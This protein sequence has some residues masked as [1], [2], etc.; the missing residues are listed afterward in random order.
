MVN[1]CSAPHIDVRRV[2]IGY[3]RITKMDYGKKIK[4]LRDEQRISRY[5]TSKRSGVPQSTIRNWETNGFVP[6]INSY[7]KVLS[8]LGYELVIRK[9]KTNE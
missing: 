3:K 2:P 9:G 5:Q 4:K 1:K 8:A 6:T 7:E